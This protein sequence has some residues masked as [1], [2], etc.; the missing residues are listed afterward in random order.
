LIPKSCDDLGALDLE[1]ILTNIADFLGSNPHEVIM[2]RAQM[3]NHEQSQDDSS[4][5]ALVSTI[6][7]VPGWTDEKIYRYPG[8]GLWPTLRDLI[9]ADK[10]V[11]FFPYLK[12]TTASAYDIPPCT[13]DHINLL[14]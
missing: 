1:E 5:A 6:Q 2:M 3:I 10:R 11:L 13:F 12:E 7:T 4:L 9:E 14:N 8:T